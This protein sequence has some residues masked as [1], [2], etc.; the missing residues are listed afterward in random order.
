M[1][2]IITFGM[3]FCCDRLVHKKHI[4]L[5]MSLAVIFVY[6]YMETYC[7]YDI[8]VLSLLKPIMHV[9]RLEGS[10]KRNPSLAKYQVVFWVKW[11][12][13]NSL[14]FIDR[15]NYG[16]LLLEWLLCFLIRATER[17][18]TF[19]NFYRRRRHYNIDSIFPFAIYTEVKQVVS[20]KV[21]HETKEL[22]TLLKS[23][24]FLS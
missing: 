12:L 17:N 1:L 24:L 4:S 6:I 19:I 15:T 9:K 20:K 14:I 16:K 22:C 3:I 13:A 11:F 10:L 7:F 8:L 23:S 2:Q 18:F 5:K 21:S